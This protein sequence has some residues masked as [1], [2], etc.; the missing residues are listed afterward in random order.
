MQDKE[1]EE[2]FR[3]KLDGFETRPSGM[4][5]ENITRQLDKKPRYHKLVP[6]LS[7]AASVIVL[8]AASIL[9]IPKKTG[10]QQKHQPKNTI[11][12]TKRQPPAVVKENSVKVQQQAN[13]QPV[14][15]AENMLVHNKPHK[16]APV[17]PQAAELEGA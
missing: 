1:F 12:Q 11:A 2:L 14:K 5:W 8:A 13:N 7:I 9:F 15:R 10:I 6:Y 3:A 4:V 17:V 16:M